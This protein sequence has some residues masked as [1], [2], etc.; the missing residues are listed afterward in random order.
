MRV[1]IILIF[2]FISVFPQVNVQET[3][4]ADGVVHKKIINTND[5]LVIN[6]LKID[7]K[8]PDISILA[9]KANELLNTKETTSQMVKRYKISG[10]DVIAAVNADFFE[11]DGEVVSNM[12][13]NG[14]IVKAVKFSD[15]PFNPF[16]NSQIASD[17]DDNLYIEQFVFS[18]NLIL[19]N[20]NVEEISRINSKSDSNSITLYNHF[21][22]KITPPSSREWYV[23]DFVLFPL[24]SIGDTLK[25]VAAAKTTLRNFEIPKEGIILSSNNKYAHYLEREIKIGDTLRIVYNFSPKIK[26][27]KSLTGGWPVLVK[28]GMNM[29]WRNTSIEG[30]TDKFSEQRHPRTGIGF[31]ADKRTLFLITVDGRQPMSKGM[32][33]IEFANLMINEGIFNGLN[34]DGGGS[35]TM[36]I[37][38]KVV[39][40]PSDAT[41]ERLVG[42]CLMVIRK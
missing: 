39:N 38:D 4:V 15:S 36:V 11:S 19:P 25:F 29:I 1:I 22:G 23:V 13:S 30:V 34:L 2:S 35:T 17:A 5:T 20:G 37:N 41:G 10:Y 14:Q 9:V 24:Q 21:Q 6:I 18:G 26:N 28:D 7:I 42:N 12:I 8:K 32:T 33:L 16:T 3:Q 40:S 27:I 31:S